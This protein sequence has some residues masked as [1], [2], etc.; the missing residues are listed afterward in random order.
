MSAATRLQ[1]LL[2]IELPII[3][4][5]MAR[6]FNGNFFCHTPPAEDVPRLSSVFTSACLRLSC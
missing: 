6:P 4:A 1:E 5:P 3:Q 2:G